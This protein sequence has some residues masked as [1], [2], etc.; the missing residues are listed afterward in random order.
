[1]LSCKLVLNT[2]AMYVLY[3]TLP[4]RHCFARPDIVASSLI[5]RLKGRLNC[6]YRKLFGIVGISTMNSGNF[7]TTT[8]PA[9]Y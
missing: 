7:N 2:S 1:M 6:E 5:K 8:A 9:C 3:P 4:V